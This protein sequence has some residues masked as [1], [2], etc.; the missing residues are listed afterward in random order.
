[1]PSLSGL[2]WTAEAKELHRRKSES[3]FKLKT[4]NKMDLSV[5]TFGTTRAEKGQSH[6]FELQ[7]GVY[8]RHYTSR[9]RSIS[10]S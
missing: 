7:V 3:K 1:M 9:E 4:K 6:L 10:S 2:I 5:S 8:L